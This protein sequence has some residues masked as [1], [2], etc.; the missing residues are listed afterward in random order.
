M[1]ACAEELLTTQLVIHGTDGDTADDLVIGPTCPDDWE[2]GTVGVLW[3]NNLILPDFPL[4]YDTLPRSRW[5]KGNILITA[6][7]DDDDVPFSIIAAGTTQ[8][9][10][11]EALTTLSAYLERPAYTVSVIVGEV[12]H[13]PWQAWPAKFARPEPVSPRRAG[14]LA[15]QVTGQIIVQPP[16]AP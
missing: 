15:I 16:G 8:T 4:I 5:A 10:L 3:F 11:T 6:T 12:T 14:M 2:S 9:L 1:T 7:E 13:G